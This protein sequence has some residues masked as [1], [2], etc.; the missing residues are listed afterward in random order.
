MHNST[1]IPS[2]WEGQYIRLEPIRLNHLLLP[3]ERIPA[4]FYVS[5]NVDSRR[6]WKSP[7][8]VLSSDEVQVLGDVVTLS[9]CDVPELSVEI[10]VSYELG[11]MLGS[12]EVIGKLETS[13]DELLD[14]GDEPFKLSFPSICDHPPSLT[15][16]A[17]VID[18]CNDQDSTLFDSLI[19]CNIARAADAGH[20][21]FAEYVSSESVS[22]LN[23]AVEHFQLVLDQCPVDHPDRAAA[24]TNLAWTRLKGYIQGD[25]QDIDYV[26]SLFREALALRPQGH[27]DHPLSLYHLAEALTRRYIKED[28]TIYIHESAQLYFKLLPFCP[29]GTYLR[30]IV[31]GENGVDYV[32]NASSN[33]PT[34]ASDE[35][36]HFRRVVLQLCPPV[37]Q[38]RPNALDELSNSLQSRF[39]LRGSVDDLDECIQHRREAVSLCSEGHPDRGNYLNDLAVSLRSRFQHQRKSHDLDDAISLHEEALLLR[40]V[41]HKYRDT[42]LSSLGGALRM[43]F[44]QRGG[45]DDIDRAI[46]LRREA[47]TLSSPGH[48]H[49]DTILNDLAIA[50]KIRYNNFDVNEDLNEAIDLY[51]KFLLLKQIDSPMRHRSLHNLSSA[52][53]SRFTKTQD[54][55]DVEEAIRLCQESLDALPSLH[56]GR[57]ASY[58]WLNEAYLSRYRVQHNIIDL[59]HAV[60]NFRL[61]SRHP[62]QGFPRRIE[63]ALRWVNE[64]EKYKH[65]SALEAYQLCLEL[66]DNHVMTRP[67]IISRHEAA[68]AFRG[69]HSLPVDAASCAIRRNDLGQA[70]ELVEQGRG[71]QWSLASRLRTP[72]EDLESTSPELARKLSELSK[73][74]SNAQGSATL[75]DRAAADIAAIQYRRLM[76]QWGA[77]VTEIRNLEGFSRF[78]LPPSYADL[79]KAARY[80]PVI[81]LIASQYLCSAI[82]V[83]TSGGPYDVRFPRITLAHLKKLKTD[84]AREI[85]QASFM[86]PTEPRKD[87]RG[88]LRVVWDEIMFPIVDVLEHNLKLRRRSRIWLC[89]TADFTSIP[90]HAANSFRMKADG[91]GPEY[92]LEDLYICSYTPTLSALIRA[93][94][95]MKNRVPPSFV[96]IGQ[97]EPGSG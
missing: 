6:R 61:A 63:T 2:S 12:G 69:A 82:V 18:P 37:H 76:E 14:H 20:A 86:G 23:N 74:L 53:S 62:T 40:P 13:W 30:G 36:I 50:L 7:V 80:G 38:R 88:L 72:L 73:S 64:A 47:L 96:A 11:R 46:S 17:T 19:D 44:I 21:Q 59:S 54:N 85:R 97:G 4:G 83:P 84:F 35:G 29:E 25:F 26:T 81:I 41:G 33:L 27:P 51:R 39:Q 22:H 16:K 75:T 31:A 9:L 90:L 91:S 48:P 77:A 95:S 56:P 57:H 89:P 45:V 58:R 87:L 24:L 71:Q 28:I 60:E 5:I 32:I 66:F 49:R 79:Q 93:Q 52:L 42:S 67:S 15:L 34:D 78:L 43:R 94:E 1:I 55:G 70:V 8:R 10:R 3:S 68:T 65:D 92:C